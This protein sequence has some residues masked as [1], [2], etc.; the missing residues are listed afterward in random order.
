MLDSVI[1]QMT[2]NQCLEDT[3][4]PGDD[5]TVLVKAVETHKLLTRHCAFNPDTKPRHWVTQSGC[6]A[7]FF[8]SVQLLAPQSLRLRQSDPSASGLRKEWELIRCRVRQF[9]EGVVA[10]HRCSICGLSQAQFQ[11][12]LLAEVHGSSLRATIGRLACWLR[13]ESHQAL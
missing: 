11:V 9:A 2:L 4:C 3:A 12:G 5:S 13:A 1:V 8:E 7:K 6:A 10:T